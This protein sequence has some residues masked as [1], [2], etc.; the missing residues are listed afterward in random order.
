M[1]DETDPLLNLEVSCSTGTIE[2]RIGA[3]FQDHSGEWEIVGF[4]QYFD[5]PTVLCKPTSGVMPSHWRRW[6]REDHSVAWCAD[7]VAA[8]LLT[9]TDGKPRDARGGL[10]TNGDR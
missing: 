8:H 7:S 6:E 2:A 3:K 9:V 1:A 4:D 10:L 5:E